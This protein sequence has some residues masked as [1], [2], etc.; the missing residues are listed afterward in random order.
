MDTRAF[1]ARALVAA[2]VFCCALEA[3]AQA[4][5][6]R[7]GLVLGGGGARGGAHLGGLEVLEQLRVPFDCV[8]AT[9]MGALVGGAYVAGVTPARMKENIRETDWNALFDDSVGREELNLRRKHLDDRFFSALEF[10]ATS[11]GLRFREGVVAGVKIKLFF[12][13][14]VGAETGERSI[15][16]LP[17]PLSLLATDIGT[18]ER[19]AMRTASLTSAMRASLSV[20]GA[21]A[22]VQRDGRKLVDGGLVDNVP[23]QEVRERCG[24]QVVIAVNVGS[25]LLPAEEVQGVLSVVAQMVNLLTEQNV[26][27][28]LAALGPDDVYMRPELGTIGAADFGRQIEAAGIGR[29]AAEA[30]ADKLRRYS[31]SPGEYAAWRRK[32]EGKPA[33]TPKID[34]VQMAETRFMDK[35]TL[36][37]QI[38]QK[39]GE[40]LD[41]KR[42][43]RDLVMLYSQGDLQGVDYSVLTERDKTILRVT[44]IEKPWGPDY[45]RFGLNLS[46]DI[47][48]A[49][50]NVRALYRRTLLNPL[51]AEWL[52]AVQIGSDQG[53]G[54]EF[55]QPFDKRQR[56]FVRPFARYDIRTVGLYRNGER[57]AEYF[58]RQWQGGAE[59]GANLGIYGEAKIGWTERGVRANVETGSSD[60]PSVDF[61]SGG[62]TGALAIDTQ[63]Y[64]FFPTQGFKVNARVFDAQRVSGDT[65]KNGLAEVRFGGAKTVGDFIFLGTLEGGAPTH[66]TLPFIDSFSLGGPRRLSGFAPNQIVG[67]EYTYG[68][69]EA[70]YRLTRPIPLV[71]LSMIAGLQAETGRMKNSVNEPTLTDWQTS[72]GAYLA[73]NTTFG[74]MFI[75]VADAKNGKTRLFIFLGTP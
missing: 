72:F 64:A 51:G 59:V 12:N 60:L 56:F 45:M 47:Y 5:R 54:T 15:E 28:S 53:I 27:R 48:D 43:D 19:V 61:R 44:P 4:P 46:A 22:P 25:P 10:G 58:A 23:V 63:D 30:V 40:P 26:A 24:A 11:Q 18:G 42:L 33:V 13:Q 9:S 65:G 70:Q 7:V 71:G 57:E 62:A 14:L 20:P 50:Y 3:L 16:D 69:L 34:Q 49:S 35:E 68:R 73:T 41:A 66:G 32:F 39:E 55:Y 36:R 17:L 21:V 38:S 29:K 74:P 2:L 6:P 8:A 52:T 1:L 75:G 67:D 37:D 31:V